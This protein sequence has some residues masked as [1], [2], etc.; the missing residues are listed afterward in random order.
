MERFCEFTWVNYGEIYFFHISTNELLAQES[1]FG[2]LKFQRSYSLVAC[3]LSL[4][5]F[6]RSLAFE[7][8]LGAPISS[9]AFS[10]QPSSSQTISLNPLF[11]M[12]N[13]VGGSFLIRIYSRKVIS[14]TSPQVQKQASLLERD[15]LSWNLNSLGPDECILVHL[16]YFV[17]VRFGTF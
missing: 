10:I 16:V 13:H 8:L 5:V 17:D 9:K 1:I 7:W 6:G 12:M 15:F 14:W 3:C 4:S 11:F 2:S